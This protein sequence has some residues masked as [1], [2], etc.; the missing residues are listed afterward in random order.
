VPD[1]DRAIR[2]VPTHWKSLEAKE[3]A[4]R[5]ARGLRSRLIGAAGGN[6]TEL[7]VIAHGFAMRSEDLVEVVE[8]IREE[9]PHADLLMIDHDG[10]HW[11]SSE[12]PERIV[13][14]I[15]RS[16]DAWFER[17]RYAAL[18]LVG[19]SAGGLLVRK[20]F[21]HAYG[22]AED[23]R[24]EDNGANE[25]QH[26]WAPKVDQILTLAAMDR[27][28]SL[29]RYAQLAPRRY[30]FISSAYSIARLFGAARFIRCFQ[31]G[32]PLVV[33]TRVQWL[34]LLY[35]ITREPETTVTGRSIP[36]SVPL[37]T[38]LIGDEDGIVTFEDNVDVLLGS[39]AFTYRV[40]TG[41]DHRSV[42]RV[43]SYEDLERAFIDALQIR[44][45]AGKAAL[46]MLAAGDPGDV[47]Y[48][49][50][51]IRDRGY[52]WIP[53]L[54]GAVRKRNPR[55][56]WMVTESY[57]YFSAL[58]FLVL[59][60]R[61]KNV[62]WFMDAYTQQMAR[63]PD[64]THNYI[65]HSNGTY[66]LASAFRLYSTCRMRN[67]VFAG[68]VVPTNYPWGALFDG[69]RVAY[70]RNY[71]GCADWVVASIP[72]LV[73]F[74][75]EIIADFSPTVPRN[76][77]LG[78]AGFNGF[79]SGQVHNLSFSCLPKSK[80]RGNHDE[81]RAPLREEL[82]DGHSVA[83]NEINVPFIV[84]SVVKEKTADPPA[85]PPLTLAATQ[86]PV[87][88]LISK[89]FWVVPFMLFVSAA[90]NAGRLRSCA[91]QRPFS[92]LSIV[93]ALTLFIRSA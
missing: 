44:G 67:V 45:H 77:D 2:T 91:A 55:P 58:S 52:G 54:A 34:R 5:E 37:V 74:I 6:A 32:E 18:S 80:D 81:Q 9:R 61:A 50:H 4:L 60:D 27:G 15:V 35:D 56:S 31:R 73:E 75:A 14:R 13:D 28:W 8:L 24:P 11:Y 79:Q 59:K 47:F 20:A 46:A 83:F 16:I 1:I 68:S 3:F 26:R 43:K 63:H 22:R 21:L 82:R 57:G 85:S 92:L 39:R 65:G 12:P 86:L 23:I 42:I 69:D 93:A 49:V 71:V 40:V 25:T 51:G 76:L 17:G 10:R 30:L 88:Q 62:R 84:E 33:N 53:K 7:F 87:V 38:Q 48:I 29:D 89:F 64:A 41:V 72:R 19:H 78:S 66:M 36:E 90:L 70:V